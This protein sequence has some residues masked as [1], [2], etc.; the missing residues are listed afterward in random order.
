YTLSLIPDESSIP[1]FSWHPDEL[2][3]D[4]ELTLT[5]P[6][7]KSILTVQ[8]NITFQPLTGTSGNETPK[9]VPIEEARVMAISEKGLSSTSATTS[10]IG[11]FTL[12]VWPNS[13]AHDLHISPI[14]ANSLMPTVVIR[15]AFTARDETILA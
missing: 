14:H 13:G 1:A 2:T 3:S 6:N 8:G 12:N 9:D 4:T 15:N 7:P 5:L 10:D 11:H